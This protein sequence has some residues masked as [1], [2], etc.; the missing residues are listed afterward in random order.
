APLSEFLLAPIIVPPRFCRRSTTLIRPSKAIPFGRPYRTHPNGP[1]K[2]LTA[3]KR[4]RPLPAH[5]LAWRRVSYHSSDHHS[6]PDSS[7]SSSPSDH[8]LSRHKP[9]DTTDA[10]SSTPQRLV[11]QSLARTPRHSEAFRRCRSAPL[12]TPYSSTTSESSLG[13]SSERLLDSSSPSSRPS[14]KRC[15]FPTASV[16]SPTYV[17]RSIAPTH[18]DLLPPRKRFRDSYSPEDSEEEHMEVDTADAEAVADVGISEGVVAHPEDGVGIG[19]E[20]AASDVRED[21]EEF[22]AEVSAAD[23]REIV[24]DPL[25]I[26]DSFESSRG[27]IPDIEDTIYDIVHYMSKVHINRI[28]EIKT[29]QRQLE[30]S[31][32]VASEERAS[33]VE[34]IRS[35]RLDYLK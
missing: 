2:L 19:F 23:T 10:D 9:L 5:R 22:E 8:S 18:A 12:S 28:A 30:T 13:S 14:R 3:R 4:V 1:R 29:T 7:S 15:R 35:L 21:D 25:A 31:Q 24:V 26:G 11:Y 20:I 16:P 32:M 34:R 17:L 27:G 33:L 6:S